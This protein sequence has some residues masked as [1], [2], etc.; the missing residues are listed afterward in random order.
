MDNTKTE[1]IMPEETPEKLVAL[2]GSQQYLQTVYDGHDH[3]PIHLMYC[4]T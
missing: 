1:A 4:L 2:V 3:L